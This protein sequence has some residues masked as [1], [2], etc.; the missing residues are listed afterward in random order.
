MSIHIDKYGRAYTT[1]KETA[2][3][4]RVKD[5]QIQYHRIKKGLPEY[6]KYVPLYYYDKKEKIYWLPPSC[7][8]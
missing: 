3:K 6:D 1:D 8:K 7:G 4:Y 2:M 5:E